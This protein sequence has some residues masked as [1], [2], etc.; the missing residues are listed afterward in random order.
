MLTFVPAAA[1][2]AAAAVAATPGA[3]V[4]IESLSERLDTR[5][6]LLHPSRANV[7]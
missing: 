7:R 5:D 2:A 4:V 3:Q 1:A 6:T